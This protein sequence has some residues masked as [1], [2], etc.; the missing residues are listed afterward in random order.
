ML[1]DEIKKVYFVII[2]CC[3]APVPTGVSVTCMEAITFEQQERLLEQQQLCQMQ[4]ELEQTKLRDLDKQSRVS[5]A[6][7]ADKSG[8][9]HN[10]E[11]MDMTASLRLVLKFNERYPDT[12][13][14]LYEHVSEAGQ[15]SDAEKILLLQCELTGKAQE[16]YSA[17]CT[18]EAL[19]HEM[20]SSTV[21]KAYQL[22]A[23]AYRQRF[24]QWV[25]GEKQTHVEFVGELKSHFQ[26]GVQL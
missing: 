10:H 12:F 2:V 15:W 23:E 3:G 18:Q 13:F 21:L 4:L 22:T 8:F 20:V 1:K 17:V 7:A 14:P 25:K 16:A 9:V 24:R 11:S 6:G 5:T 26:L 19:A